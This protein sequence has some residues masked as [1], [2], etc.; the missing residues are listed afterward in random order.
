VSV[1]HGRDKKLESETNKWLA[2]SVGES[3][4]S[5]ARDVENMKFGHISRDELRHYDPTNDWDTS[6][7][8]YQIADE[9]E[10]TARI[11]QT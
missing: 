3:K 7:S 8:A 6:D 10:A 2:E 9:A 5:V 1:K 11:A 4:R